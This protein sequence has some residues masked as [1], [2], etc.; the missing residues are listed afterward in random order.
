MNKML[1]KELKDAAR[2]KRLVKGARAVMNSEGHSLVVLSNSNGSTFLKKAAESA[3]KT[4]VPTL[5]YDGTSVALGKLC[6]LQFRVSAL[7]VTGVNESTAQSIIR[8]NE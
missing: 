3:E 1:A 4:G 2:E 7:A 5:K 6:G 8:E